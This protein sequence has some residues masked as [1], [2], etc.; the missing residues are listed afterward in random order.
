ME[1]KEAIIRSI[2]R[3]CRGKGWFTR[4]ERIE[5]WARLRNKVARGETEDLQEFHGTVMFDLAE[6]GVN[7]DHLPALPDGGMA[8]VNQLHGIIA[9]TIDQRV[10]CGAD[11]NDAILA[12]PLDGEEHIGKC[13]KCGLEISYRPPNLDGAKEE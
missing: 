10:G 13:L 2:G 7:L 6:K 12:Q 9:R 5:L 8:D 3:P 11:F 4:E 1:E